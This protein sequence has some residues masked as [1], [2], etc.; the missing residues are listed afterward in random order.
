[1]SGTSGATLEQTRVILVEMPRMLGEIVREVV[2]NEP[3]LEIVEAD[4]GDAALATIGA[5]GAC[6]VITRRE[7]P[8]RERIGRWLGTG[9]QVRVLALSTDGR[10][11]ALYELQ[12]QERLLGEI[13]PPVLLAAIR[14]TLT[15]QPAQP[16]SPSR[17]RFPF[18]LQHTQD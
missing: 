13:S 15:D 12:P 3:D 18:S 4:D 17:Q 10:D 11:G 6:V 5:S 9:P 7:D 8:V 1:M 2:S 16:C 14:D